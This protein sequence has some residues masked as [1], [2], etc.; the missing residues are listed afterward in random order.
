MPY[1]DPR[2]VSSDPQDQTAEAP[3]GI[4]AWSIRV[5]QHHPVHLFDGLVE[6]DVLPRDSR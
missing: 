6:S 2:L 1:G 5:G 3:E 4:R